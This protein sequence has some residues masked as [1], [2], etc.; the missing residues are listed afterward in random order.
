[1]DLQPSVFHNFYIYQRCAQ[2]LTD[3]GVDL[4]AMRDYFELDSAV[5]VK[6]STISANRIICTKP[7]AVHM[8]TLRRT[9]VG[10]VLSTVVLGPSQPLGKHHHIFAREMTPIRS[11]L[12]TLDEP[13]IRVE[14]IT[15][16]LSVEYTKDDVKHNATKYVYYNKEFMDSYQKQKN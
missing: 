8:E 7:F 3:H 13:S 2:L 10:P 16:A 9:D 15:L 5:E 11:I 4:P 14:H 6:S 12:R 1:M